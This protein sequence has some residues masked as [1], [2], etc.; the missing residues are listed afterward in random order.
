M[1][2]APTPDASVRPAREADAGAVAQTTVLAWRAAYADL[3]PPA[4]L[5]GLD[6]PTATAT[7]RAAILEPG[8]NR[9][10][11][12]CAGPEVVGYVSIGPG[13]GPGAELGEIE[14]R[15]EHRRNGHGSRL[16]AAAVSHL[17]GEGF[18]SVLTWAGESDRAR[19]Q[20]L[21]SA[22]FAADG[23]ARV[24]DLDGSGTVTLRQQR[25]S[26]LLA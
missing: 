11:V 22:G 13:D 19:T 12:A 23:L 24:L 16:L 7:W 3:L 6:L 26:A 18:T 25:W 8:P 1:T 2:T 10:L 9:L 21:D 20:F 17:R 5:A 4:V 15:P 14:V